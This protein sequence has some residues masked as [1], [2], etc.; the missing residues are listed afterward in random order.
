ML[1]WLLILYSATAMAA[2]DAP[3]LQTVIEHVRGAYRSA[4][5]MRIMRDVYA[6]D[7]YF[8]FPRFDATAEYLKRRMQ[9]AGLTGVELVETP[10]DGITQVGFWTMPLAWDVRS[11]RLEILDDSVPAARVL[12]DYEKIPSSL[13]MGFCTQLAPHRSRTDLAVTLKL[14]FTRCWRLSPL[15][16][17]TSALAGSAGCPLPCS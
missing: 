13:G 10:A 15:R 1:R 16:T 11:A 12:A 4:D 5:A 3:D 14:A 2:A 7:R 17:S 9:D 8:T 6:S